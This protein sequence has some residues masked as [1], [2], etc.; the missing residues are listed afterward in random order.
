MASK[1]FPQDF[2]NS[3]MKKQVIETT[4]DDTMQTSFDN[5]NYNDSFSMQ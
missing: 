5:F 1:H 2:F 4:N 3:K